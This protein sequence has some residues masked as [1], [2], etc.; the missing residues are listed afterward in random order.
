MSEIY[1]ENN[2]RNIISEYIWLYFCRSSRSLLQSP[3]H[4]YRSMHIKWLFFAFAVALGA[5]FTGR[6]IEFKDEPVFLRTT[7]AQCFLITWVHP[8]P[9]CWRWYIWCCFLCLSPKLSSLVH[10]SLR[11]STSASLVEGM[12]S[13][14]LSWLLMQSQ[15]TYQKKSQRDYQTSCFHLWT[16]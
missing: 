5:F 4:W 2:F 14:S 15:R 6:T 1:F 13:L 10:C 12:L 3:P 7:W 9:V 16:L 11:R 8:N